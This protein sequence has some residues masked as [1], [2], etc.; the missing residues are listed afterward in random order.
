MGEE[1][2]EEVSTDLFLKVPETQTQAGQ[3]FQQ[4]EVLR[5]DMLLVMEDKSLRMSIFWKEDEDIFS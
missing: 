4:E 2:T 3:V 1:D 5:G